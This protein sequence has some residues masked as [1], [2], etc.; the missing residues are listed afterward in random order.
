MD[1]H[2]VWQVF[3]EVEAMEYVGVTRVVIGVSFFFQ[4]NPM[5]PARYPLVI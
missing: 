2:V 3:G 4:E 1:Q 5:K